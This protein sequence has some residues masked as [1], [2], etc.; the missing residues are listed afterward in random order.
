[1]KKKE[2]LIVIVVIAF[3]VIYNFVKSG[4][5]RF[6]SG[7]SVGSRELLD[8]KHPVSFFQEEIE[9]TAGA[10]PQAISKWKNQKTVLSW[11]N[12]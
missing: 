12:R 3:G 11:L 9:F 7:C 2:I 1:M 10:I 8:R 5:V 4:D 6:Y